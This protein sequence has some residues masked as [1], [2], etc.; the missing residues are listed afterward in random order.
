MVLAYVDTGHNNLKVLRNASVRIF[1][2]E[3]FCTQALQPL[4]CWDGG[5]LSRWGRGCL[6]LL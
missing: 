2:P 3:V 4:A 5:Y 1:E 6:S